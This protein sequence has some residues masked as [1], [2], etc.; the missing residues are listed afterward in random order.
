[1][2]VFRL[3]WMAWLTHGSALRV[4][5]STPEGSESL[6]CD[7]V[8]H[9]AGRVPNLDQLQLETANVEYGPLGI[10]VSDSM[11]SVSNPAVFSA[12][13]CADTPAP[14][15]TPVSAYEARIAFKN[16]LAEKDERQASYPAIPSMVFTI[17]P[18]GTGRGS[19][20]EEARQQGMDIDV[21]FQKTGHWY[22]SLRVA[23]TH[24]AYKVIVNK[25]TGQVVGAHLIGPGAEEQLNLLAL[26]MNA[27]LT[28][29][30]I[31]AA[32]FAYPSYASDLGSMV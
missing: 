25:A 13:D 32:I 17:P 4:D 19:L 20:E 18:R 1:M 2:S 5:M 14:N 12:G 24:S 16:L 22:S 15:L 3:A 27:G 6:E 9:G 31:K 23:E 7:A 10:K 28:S 26:A 8:V 21:H 29:N 30:Q 11:R